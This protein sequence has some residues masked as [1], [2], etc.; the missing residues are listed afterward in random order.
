MEIRSVH[1][2]AKR[3]WENISVSLELCGNIG[4]FDLV[5]YI[6]KEPQLIRNLI[7]M[8]KKIPEHDYLTMEAA[9]VFTELGKE[10]GERLGLTS[11][12]AKAFGGGYSWVRT[13]WFDLINLEFD[14]FEIL[15]D[16]LTR[17][18]FFF[19]LF[20]PLKEDFS[21]VF[22]STDVTLNFKSIF[23]RFSSWQN[24]PVGYDRDLER[25][26]KDIEPIREGLASA[27]DI[28]SGRC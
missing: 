25:Y 17:K 9:Y 26:K 7:G 27:L 23:D 16:H 18:I 24:D 1:Q 11:E 3:E 22:D 19:R 21:W 15:E 5:R 20:F 14:D 13:G 4:K 28:E 2:I 10:A 12:L 8:E 6:E